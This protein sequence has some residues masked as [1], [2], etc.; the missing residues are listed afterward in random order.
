MGYGIRDRDPEDGSA[1]FN[2]Y[3]DTLKRLGE[4]LRELRDTSSAIEITQD[5]KQQRKIALVKQFFLNA[6]PLLKDEIVFVYRDRVLG[7]KESTSRVANVGYGGETKIMGNT[8]IYD[9]KLE[10]ELD[11]ILLE[12]QSVLQKEKYFMPP[13]HDPRFGW[14]QG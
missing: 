12:L 1:P 4:I 7:L 9:P 6:V 13:K 8:L 11:Q 14:G 2:I 10:I 3:M 5:I